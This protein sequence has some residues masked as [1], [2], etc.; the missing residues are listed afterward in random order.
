MNRR[1]QRKAATRAGMLDA[2]AAR[3]RT[4]GPAATGVADVMA[5]AGLTHGGFYGHFAGKE[6]MLRA[7]FHHAMSQSRE[8]WFAGLENARGE[9]RLRW[10][11]GRYPTEE[12]SA[13]L[14]PRSTLRPCSSPLPPFLGERAS[15]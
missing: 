8:D 13:S 2:A 15:S 14:R 10:L 7:A 4:D 5:D 11:A 3:L 12:T 1:Q 6:A 9:E